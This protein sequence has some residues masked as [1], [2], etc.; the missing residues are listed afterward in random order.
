[1]ST[2]QF[3]DITV[4]EW[5]AYVDGYDIYSGNKKKRD[6]ALIAIEQLRK[7]EVKTPVKSDGNEQTLEGILAK[8]Q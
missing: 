5:N 1:M 7:P 4:H 6:E 3:W 2:T 8:W